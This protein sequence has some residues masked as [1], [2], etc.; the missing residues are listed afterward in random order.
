M[1]LTNL[2][3]FLGAVRRLDE[4]LDQLAGEARTTEI[5]LQVFST[6][7]YF[8]EVLIRDPE[9]LRLAPGRCRASRIAS[10]LVEEL[11]RRVVALDS[12]EEQK[13]AFRR[14]RQPREP[15]DRLQRHRPRIPAGGDHAGPLPPGRR[16]RRGR[17]PAGACACRGAVRRPDDAAGP[18]RAVRR[19]GA[20]QARRRGAQLQLG[21]RPDLPL[22]RRGPD[23]RPEG[24][25]QRRVLRAGWA[26]RSSGC[27]PSTRR[28]GWPIA[29][30]CGSAPTA[31]KAR[32][33]GRWARPSATT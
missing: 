6:S 21:H 19:A 17:R 22:R 5:L 26:A 23:D 3:R 9:L 31:N 24:R 15:A 33:P 28:W 20:G 32:W 10:A 27:W 18:A 2:E 11:W 29:S 30:T 7:Q 16:L 1:A 13:L 4:T 8:S 25:L 12:E 14:F